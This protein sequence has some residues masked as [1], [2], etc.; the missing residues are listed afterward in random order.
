[1]SFHPTHGFGVSLLGAADPIKFTDPMRTESNE[2]SVEGKIHRGKQSHSIKY[3]IIVVIISALIFVAVISLFDVIRSFI[4]SYF[5]SIAFNNPL[6]GLTPLTI[7]Q[8]RI[9]NE[10]TRRAS[11]VFALICVFLAL[12]LIPILVCLID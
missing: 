10:E 5:A 2:T 4:V 12:I 7:E 9:S 11:I 8:N 3:T 6:S 1:M